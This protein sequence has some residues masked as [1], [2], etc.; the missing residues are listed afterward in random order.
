[1]DVQTTN[2]RGCE[3]FSTVPPS[4]APK[5]LRRSLVI[6]GGV[7]VFALVGSLANPD[8]SLA[9]DE[10]HGHVRITGGGSAGAAAGAQ[11]AMPVVEAGSLIGTLECRE[12]RILIK[13]ADPAPLYTVCTLDGRVLMENLEAEDMYREFPTI[14]MKRLYVD[15]PVG[16]D[17][18]G[19]LML[20]YP[21]D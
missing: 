11:H 21:T 10:R 9:G 7:C 17:R 6:A 20:V 8:W 14:D 18:S 5:W 2:T 13:H 15:P 3:K 1:M 12:Y 16:S 19:P 4:S